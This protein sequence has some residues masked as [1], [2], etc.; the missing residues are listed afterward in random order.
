MST[1][2]TWKK[3]AAVTQEAEAALE[4]LSGRFEGWRSTRERLSPI[5]DALWAGAVEAA[6]EQGLNRVVRRLGLSY[7][8]LKRRMYA[9]AQAAPVGNATG[10]VELIAPRPVGP[11]EFTV[12]LESAT[13]AKMRIA[14]KGGH[15]QEVLALSRAFWELAR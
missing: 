7:S 6:R 5:P 2:K 11:A 13:G 4:E 1:G 8:E 14:L 15:A 9:S 3:S 12:E 10:F